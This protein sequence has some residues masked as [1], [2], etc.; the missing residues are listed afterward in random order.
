DAQIISLS[1][2]RE[3]SSAWVGP[4]GCSSS[5]GRAAMVT[6]ARANSA[7]ARFTNDSSASERRPTDP[8]IHQ[9]AVFMTIVSAATATDRRSR[10]VTCM[11][12]ASAQ[13][14]AGELALADLQDEGP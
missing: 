9:A 11:V 13:G 6:I 4:N 12:V 2:A 5:A 10:V 8:V 7:D 1:T 14:H 3:K